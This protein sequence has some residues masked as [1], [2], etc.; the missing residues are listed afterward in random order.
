MQLK[1]KDLLGIEQLTK[2]EI[3]L[4]LDQADSFKEIS[5][6]EIKKV[7]AFA[8]KRSCSFSWSRAPERAVV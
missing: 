5:T 4:I 7:P 2:E 1:G 8:A 6:R 3:E